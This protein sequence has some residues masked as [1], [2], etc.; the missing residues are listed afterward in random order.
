MTTMSTAAKD[1]QSAFTTA[2]IATANTISCRRTYLE[3]N[4][5]QPRQVCLMMEQ[6]Q[7]GRWQA[8][9]IISGCA[10]WRTARGVVRSPRR[11]A[12]ESGSSGGGLFD[13][14]APQKLITRWAQRLRLWD[15]FG[16]C[17]LVVS[18]ILSRRVCAQSLPCCLSL[19]HWMD[20]RIP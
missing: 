16:I 18:V 8:G 6:Q 13:D 3:T 15:H 17:W 11:I 10:Q 7:V 2:T 20:S 19:Q 14:G 4:W 9:S 5:R 12:K 1:W